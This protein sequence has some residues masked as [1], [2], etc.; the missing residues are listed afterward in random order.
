MEL[1]IIKIIQQ[2]TTKVTKSIPYKHSSIHLTMI[3]GGQ[4]FM[5]EISQIT[6][7][8][9]LSDA[10]QIPVRVR[11]IKYFFQTPICVRCIK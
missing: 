8:I 2:H 7:M 6:R 11:Y 10:F 1:V 9:I 5:R 4:L 3:C